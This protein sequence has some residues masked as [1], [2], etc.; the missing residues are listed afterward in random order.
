MA[1]TDGT[2]EKPAPKPS[3]SSKPSQEGKP[4]QLVHHDPSTG[5]FSLGDEA[6]A[7]LKRVKAPIAVVSVCGRAR[8]GKSYI[9]NQMIGTPGAGFEVASSYRPCT[10]GLWLW[11]QPIRRTALDGSYYYLVLIDTEG[12]D[13]YDQ[14]TQDG[15]SLF[16]LALLL[17]SLFVYNQMGGI[18]EAALDRLALVTELTRRIR[19]RTSPGAAAAAATTGD[20]TAQVS[21]NGGKKKDAEGTGFSRRKQESD[22]GSKKKTAESEGGLEDTSALSEFTPSFMWLLRDFYYDLEDKGVRKSPRD[23]LET[24]LMPTPGKGPAVE[25]KNMIRESIKSLF[26]DRD[27]VTLVRPVADEEALRNLAVL[28]ADQL[29]PE[30]AQGVERLTATLN[31]RAQPKRLGTQMLTGPLLA[32]LAAAYVKAINQGAVPTISTAW[33][34]VAE[35]EC[36]A[37]CYAAEDAYRAA[38]NSNTL[39]DEQALMDEHQ[40]SLVAAFAAFKDRAVGDPGLQARYQQRYV[41]ACNTA[42]EAVRERRL[43]AAAE[44]L[45]K[46][47]ADLAAKLHSDVRLRDASFP[48]IAAAVEAGVAAVVGGTVGAARWP[49]L[50]AFCHSQYAALGGEMYERTAQAAAFEAQRVHLEAQTQA[51]EMERLRM[52]NDG[53]KA[54]LAAA[55]KRADEA[56]AARDEAISAARAAAA[57]STVR[58]RGGDDDVYKPASRG[59]FGC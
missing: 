15:V 51:A 18:D 45:E 47:L 50:L 37:A 2:R 13:A 17:S 36:R 29:R 28:P 39:A 21:T 12:I 22:G 4:V 53:L 1:V 25:T 48:Q 11:S 20:A 41:T 10:K 57:R 55:T 23:Y 6:I 43:A 19:V 56:A 34:S 31:A 26:P 33:H 14:T 9:L 8:T 46:Q 38:F 24:A 27:C 44:A 49:R 7:V 54:Q 59:C 42:F 40:R 35:S 3:A 5:Q 52:E 30:F 58:G 16:S 32:G